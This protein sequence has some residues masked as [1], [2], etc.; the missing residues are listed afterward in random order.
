MKCLNNTAIVLREDNQREESIEFS[1]KAIEICKK[2]FGEIHLEMAYDNWTLSNTYAKFEDKG[3]ALNC[4]NKTIS[5]LEKLL[6]PD[7]PNILLAYVTRN[8]LR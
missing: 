7:H 4:I 6:P 3:E 2:S 8:K 5:I 1:G